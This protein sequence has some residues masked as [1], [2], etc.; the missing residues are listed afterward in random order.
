VLV[1]AGYQSIV[2]FSILTEIYHL[3]GKENRRGSEMPSHIVAVTLAKS[4]SGILGA[5]QRKKN[6]RNKSTSKRK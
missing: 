2:E 1:E 6:K 5:Y 3:G 4:I